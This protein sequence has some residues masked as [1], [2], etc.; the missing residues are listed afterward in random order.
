MP[1][2]Q[3]AFIVGLW[4]FVSLKWRV[5]LKFIFQ[6][7]TFT[8]LILS[9][10]QSSL[11]QIITWSITLADSNSRFHQPSVKSPLC[12]QELLKNYS[13]DILFS[14]CLNK[15]LDSHSVWLVTMGQTKYEIWQVLLQASQ[16]LRY[17]LSVITAQKIYY[18][19]S[20]Y[21]YCQ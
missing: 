14:F 16:I 4:F 9:S 5:R 17:K 8:P 3:L 2:I 15:F 11:L 18:Y 13:I 10:Q 6:Q 20:K 19:L 12:E 7:I 1:N 21:Y